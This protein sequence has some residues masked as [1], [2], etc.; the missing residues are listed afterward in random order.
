VGLGNKNVSLL[1][2]RGSN[3]LLVVAY[4][5]LAPNGAKTTTSKFRRIYCANFRVRTLVFSVE[6]D[7]QGPVE[8][9][10]RSLPLPVL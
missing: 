1:T 6:K 4:K 7:R 3:V 2:E 5:H 8:F 10:I 9:L